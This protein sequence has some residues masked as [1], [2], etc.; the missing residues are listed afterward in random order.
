MTSWPPTPCR[1]DSQ[2]KMS[3]RQS[4]RQRRRR[5]RRDQFGSGG[6]VV[7]RLIECDQAHTH[8]VF[9]TLILC[10]DDAISFKQCYSFTS[11]IL[12]VSVVSQLSTSSLETAA[13]HVLQLVFVQLCW[14]PPDRVCH[15]TASLVVIVE[16]HESSR[17]GDVAIWVAFDLCC[18]WY[19]N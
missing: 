16:Y 3:T 1:D 15:T 8:S 17:R 18:V 7:Q 6:D 11:S 9:L 4:W 10:G 13:Y 2:P 5:R 12:P 14:P 19:I